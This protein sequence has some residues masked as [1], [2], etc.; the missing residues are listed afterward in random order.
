MFKQRKCCD[1]PKYETV[2]SFYTYKEKEHDF[3]EIGSPYRYTTITVPDSII[4]RIVEKVDGMDPSEVKN[5]IH[6][7]LQTIMINLDKE[8]R[9]YVEIQRCKN[10]GYIKKVEVKI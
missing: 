8:K 4:D 10:C 9:S 7:E 2:S 3:Y 1:N 5:I 6:D